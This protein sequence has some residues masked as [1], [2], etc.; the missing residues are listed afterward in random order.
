[1]GKRIQQ[2]QIKNPLLQI[3][4]GLSS[5]ERG[6]QVWEE[7]PVDIVEFVESRRFLNSKWNGSRGCRPK[8]LDILV[9]ICKQEVREVMLLLGKGAGKDYLSAITHLYGI[10][11]CLCML[12]PQSYFGL[13]PSPIYF[14][15]TARND[16][17]AKKVFFTQFRSL[18]LDCPWFK[19]KYN[20]PGL[21]SVT[22]I[23][24]IEAIS[25]NSQ[26]FGW[27]G[28]NTLQWVGDELAFFLENDQDD[29]SDSRAQECWEAAFGSCKTRFPKDYKMIGITTPRYDD[30]FVMTKFD[31]LSSRSDG[32]VKQA[33]TWDINPNLVK[34]DFA[35][36]LKRDYRR[37]M[38]DFGAIPSG[39]IESFWPEP[40]ILETLVCKKCK[41]C[42]IWQNRKLNKDIYACFDYEDCNANAYMGN[43]EWRDWFVAPKENNEF[44]M[45][46]DL[47]I[48]ECRLGFALG[49]VIGETKVELDAYR[50]KLKKAQ[51]QNGLGLNNDEDISQEDCFEEKPIIHIAA[52]GWVSTKTHGRDRNL[53]I[54]NEYDY[55]A[56]MNHCILNLQKRKIN[57]VG[58]TFDQFQSQMLRQTLESKG[59]ETDL[60]SMDRTDEIP[61]AAKYSILENRVEYPYSYLLCDEAKYLKHLNG[62]KVTHSKKKSKDLFDAFAGTIWDC[63]SRVGTGGTFYD[64]SNNNE[65]DD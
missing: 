43:G 28:Y 5:N 38:R 32:Y 34:E 56:V 23:K 48:S 7:E 61:V 8:I 47:A 12:N 11:K 29:E 41:E 3:A 33:A 35:Y 17:Q 49:H 50:I 51:K 52:L 53:L 16:T 21:Q 39:V 4:Q 19:G 64:I 37:T 65:D 40:E 26:A 36:D 20:D 55:T 18:L 15:N 25:V 31:E 62:K 60:I 58:I 27:L 59:Y 44:W 45:H 1:M 57:V 2:N 6:E 30:D 46:F 13:A 54:N 24:D 42:P 14:V 10:Y 9:V 22:F 63:E